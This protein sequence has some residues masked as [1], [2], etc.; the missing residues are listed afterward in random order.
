[1]LQEFNLQL[2]ALPFFASLVALEIAIFAWRGNSPYRWRESLASIAIGIG[3]KLVNLL[4]LGVPAGVL[5]FVW[6]N[7]LAEVPLDTSWGLVLLFLGVELAYYWFHRLSHEVRW[8]WATHAVHHSPEHLNILAA[9]RLGWTG[10][11]SGGWLLF[12]PLIFVGFHPAAVFLTLALNLLYQAW[13][14]TD[15]IPKLGWLEYVLN[16]PS[17]HRVHHAMNADYLDRN[18]GGVL[19]IFDRLFGTYVEERDHEPCQYGLVTPVGSQNPV[20][21]AFH[22]WLRMGRDALQA[23]SLRDLSGYLFGP[24]GWKPGGQGQTSEDIRRA[25]RAKQAAEGVSPP[26][27]PSA[28]PRRRQISWPALALAILVLGGLAMNYA[29]A[30]QPSAATR[31]ACMSDY[32]AHCSGVAPGGGRVV[33]C[34]RANAEKLSPACREALKREEQSR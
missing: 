3:S 13:I 34:M 21:I 4:K 14:H 8:L 23:K 17:N 1:M 2:F 20:T 19:I 12:T 24:P 16:T 28:L 27:L 22:E 29:L 31:A 6:N 9:Y 15:L 11:L 18:Y 10:L 33:A 32:R 25:W 7:R 5:Y 26:E 30:Q